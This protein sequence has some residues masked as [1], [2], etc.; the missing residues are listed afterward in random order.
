MTSWSDV[1]W[2]TT[3]QGKQLSEKPFKVQ[4][5]FFKKQTRERTGLRVLIYTSGTNDTYNTL[6]NAR[7]KYRPGQWPCLVLLERKY[8]QHAEKPFSYTNTKVCTS[9]EITLRIYIYISTKKDLLIVPPYNIIKWIQHK[10]RKTSAI[11]NN[12]WRTSFCF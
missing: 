11:R 1:K 4:K 6:R 9:R 12:F 3:W 7:R 8:C 2:T 5:G 10:Q